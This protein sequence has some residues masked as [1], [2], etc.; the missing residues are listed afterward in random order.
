[1]TSPTFVLAQTYEGSLRLHHLDAYRLNSP[2]ELMLDLAVPELLADRA[3]TAIEWGERFL[4]H[5]PHDYLQLRFDLGRV[6]EPAD[7]REI[8][9][10]TVGASWQ[11]RAQEL[12]RATAQWART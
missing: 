4:E 5:L 6:D 7:V 10:E 3:V 1:V 8:A 11:A 12:E 9:L 2:E